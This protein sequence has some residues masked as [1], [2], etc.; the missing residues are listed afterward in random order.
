MNITAALPTSSP[1]NFPDSAHFK[2]VILSPLRLILRVE[3]PSCLNPRMPGIAAMNSAVFWYAGFY[4]K[5]SIEMSTAP[6]PNRILLCLTFGSIGAQLLSVRHR[7]LS[8]HLVLLIDMI[9]LVWRKKFCRWPLVPTEL[10][11]TI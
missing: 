6:P 9:Q 4:L 7:T 8:L 5:F 11:N 3:M 2:A 1:L 10:G